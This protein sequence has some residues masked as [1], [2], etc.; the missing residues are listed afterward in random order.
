MFGSTSN[1]VAR[2]EHKNLPCKGKKAGK[3]CVQGFFFCRLN[4]KNCNNSS[5]NCKIQLESLSTEIRKGYGAHGDFYC[6]CEDGFHEKRIDVKVL[7]V[8]AKFTGRGK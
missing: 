5:R 7:S 1:S 6:V 3:G 2:F 4:R 8:I